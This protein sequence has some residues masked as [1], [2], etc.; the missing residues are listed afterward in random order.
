MDA[1]VSAAPDQLLPALQQF[2]WEFGKVRR[3]PGDGGGFLRASPPADAQ[4]RLAQGDFSQWVDLFNH[5]DAWLE[6]HIKPRKDLALAAPPSAA[7]KPF[8]TETCLQV[9]RVTSLLLDNCSNKHMYGST[10]VRFR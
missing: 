2:T 7:P 1:I 9:L 3:L 10:E 8:P 6:T 4:F 5:L